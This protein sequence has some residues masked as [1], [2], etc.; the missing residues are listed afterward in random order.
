[1]LTIRKVQQSDSD[2]LLQWRN[3]PEVYKYAL[4]PEP[5]KEC[6]HQ[7]WFKKALINPR[8]IF[9]M[10]LS[11]GIPCG[12]VRYQLSENLI[13]AEVSIS[14]SPDFWGK[15]IASQIMQLGE[16]ALKRDSSV[17]RIHAIVL[18]ENIAS[19]KL[20]ERA[21]FEPLLTKFKKDI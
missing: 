10:G 17:K 20:F 1:M 16:K 2:I 13:E 6:D 11:D 4:N 9:Y 19:M 18:S 15:G 14:V 8:C 5:V 12:S 7:D 21:N 3:N